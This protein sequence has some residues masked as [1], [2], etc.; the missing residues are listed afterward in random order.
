MPSDRP[1][2]T[3]EHIQEFLLQLLL[4]LLLLLLRLLVALLLRLLYNSYCYLYL[5]FDSVRLLAS[6]AVHLGRQNIVLGGT[7]K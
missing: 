1:A 7:G 2:S 5:S 6:P 3:G 4:L